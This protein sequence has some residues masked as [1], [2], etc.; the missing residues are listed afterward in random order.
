MMLQ[1]VF[2]ATST[3]KEPVRD[4]LKSLDK[5]DKKKIGED[6]KTLQFGWPIGM[7]LTRKLDHNL[8]E[9]RSKLLNKIARIIFTLDG[10]QIVLLHGFIKKSQRIPKEDLRLAQLRLKEI[11][12]N[13]YEK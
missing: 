12:G 1:I 2:Y 6:V 7:P 10:D 4:W 3:G 11:K 13:I 5:F 9:I 8:W